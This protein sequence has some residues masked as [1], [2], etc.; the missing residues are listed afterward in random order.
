MYF[1]F[2]AVRSKLE[3]GELFFSDEPVAEWV[4]IDGMKQLLGDFA[5]R[6]HFPRPIASVQEPFSTTASDRSSS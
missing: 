3:G 1:S 6:R 2:L 5:L 4:W